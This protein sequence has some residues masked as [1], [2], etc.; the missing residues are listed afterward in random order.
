MSLK[1]ENHGRAPC[2][3]LCAIPAGAAV[4]RLHQF[5]W[6]TKGRNIAIRV[7]KAAGCTDANSL[8]Q[9]FH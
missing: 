2:S 9:S 5:W 3:F 6:L 8:Q 7:V 4:T 1:R